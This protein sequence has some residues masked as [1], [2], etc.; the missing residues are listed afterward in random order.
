[1]QPQEENLA[2][3]MPTEQAV[4]TLFDQPCLAVR[5]EQGVIYVVIADI[6]SALGIKGEAQLRRIRQHEQLRAGLAT[7][8]IRQGNRLAPANCLHLQLTA[9]W[10]MQI[11]T[12]RVREEVRNRLRYLQLHLLDTVWRAFASLSGLPAQI[13]QIEDLQDIDRIDQALRALEELADRQ[14][15]IEQSQERARDVWRQMMDRLHELSGRMAELEQRV[16]G[17]LS[18]AQRGH[19][20]H[21]VQAWGVARAERVATISKGSVFATCWAELKVRFSVSRYEDLTPAQYTEAV[22]YVKLQ[23]HALTGTELVLPAQDELPL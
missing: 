7:F 4:I 8:R 17:K 21:L 1:M 14:T 22:A 15:A 11:S 2:I 19:L 5:D 12:A 16:G 20:Y 6:C 10:L 13:E 9:G 23:Y 3:R 18:P